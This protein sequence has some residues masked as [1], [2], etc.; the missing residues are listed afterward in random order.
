ML[1][2]GLTA[3]GKQGIYQR[4]WRIPYRKRLRLTRT[5]DAGEGGRVYI[6]SGYYTYLYELL[7]RNPMFN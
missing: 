5:R 1:Q 7:F 2:A 3:L 4:G 6:G